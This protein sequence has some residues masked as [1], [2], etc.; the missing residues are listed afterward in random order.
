MLETSPVMITLTDSERAQL[1]DL[2]TKAGTAV[3]EEPPADRI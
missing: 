2:L 1:R 3:A